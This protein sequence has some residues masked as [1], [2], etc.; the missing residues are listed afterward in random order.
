MKTKH[1]F[2]FLLATVFSLVC[3]TPKAYA[4]FSDEQIAAL[5]AKVKSKV[6]VG[7]LYYHLD[8]NAK[9]NEKL[10][11]VVPASSSDNYDNYKGL[12]NA[13]IPPY[14]T[15]HNETYKVVA[16]QKIAFS[17][18]KDLKSVSIPST[19]TEI[20]GSAFNNSGLTSINLDGNGTWTSVGLDAFS[21]TPYFNTASNWENGVVLYINNC[22]IKATNAIESLKVKE[23]T[24]ILADGC[25]YL[26]YKE[27]VKLTEVSLPNSVEYIGDASFKKCVSL[28]TIHMSNAV[29]KIGTGAFSF[30]KSLESIEL[31]A[32][33]TYIE[34]ES[35]AYSTALKD[36]YCKGKV[37]F[38]SKTF[39]SVDVSNISVHFPW[40]YL[41][42]YKKEW[43][44]FNLV[45]E[46]FI[47][48]GIYYTVNDATQTAT[49]A[50]EKKGT[51]NYASLP[52][53][54][55]IP[56]TIK[57]AQGQEYKVVG[58]E[59]AAFSF[60]PIKELV[61]EAEI[62][63][64]PDGALTWAD[65][66]TKVTL[67]ASVRQISENAFNNCAVLENIPGLTDG[68][69]ELL[70]NLTI[71]GDYAFSDCAKLQNIW[72]ESVTDIGEDAFSLCTELKSVTL[73][74]KVKNIGKSAFHGCTALEKM[75]NKASQ[76]QTFAKSMLS[77]VDKEKFEIYVPGSSLNDYQT[78]EGW[79]DYTILGIYNQINGLYYKLNDYNRTATIV[80]EK[81]N[82]NDNYANLPKKLTI[83]EYISTNGIEYY[84]VTEIEKL[85][86]MYAPVKEVVL[87]ENIREIGS[88]AFEASQLEEINIPSADVSINM[89]AFRATKLQTLELPEGFTSVP[90]SLCLNCSS[91]YKVVL[92]SS[93][94]KISTSAFYGC[95][96]LGTIT[97][98]ENVTEIEKQA[99][100]N[101][102]DLYAIYNLNKTP[103]TI[104]AN[105]FE[106][107]T[108]SN[109]TLYVPTGCKAAY[110]AKD[111]WKEFTIKELNVVVDGLNYIINNDAK[112]AKLTF[113]NLV[114]NYTGLSGKVTIPATI[115]FNDETY[116]VT[117]I[118]N[119]AF[120]GNKNITELV[121]PE[122]IQKIG[123]D[124]IYNAAKIA[125]M[126]IPS[127]VNYIYRIGD[128]NPL[129]SNDANYTDGLL[130]I[131]NCLLKAK[132]DLSGKITV[133]DGTRLIAGYA[134]LGC[135][136][137]T[138]I[139]LPETVQ[140]I[141]D[142]TFQDCKKLQGI[143]IPEGIT[144]LRRGTFEYCDDL[145]TYGHAIILP[146]SLVT[147][148][149][150]VFSGCYNLREIT[151]P[152]NVRSIGNLMFWDYSNPSQLQEL[153][154]PAGIQELKELAFYDLGKLV[155]F[156]CFSTTPEDIQLGD[157]VFSD[158]NASATLFVPYGYKSKYEALD[159]WKDLKI[160]EM[161]VQVNG[162]Y[163]ET[164]DVHHTAAVTREPG[165]SAPMYS[166]FETTSLTIP[167][168]IQVFNEGTQTYE[169]YTVDFMDDSAFDGAPF[170]TVRL[171]EGMK[172]LGAEVFSGS[173]LETVYLPS[174]IN[175]LGSA[176]MDCEHLKTV[177]CY[178]PDPIDIS[179][180]PFE[181]VDLP[182]A[183]LYVP[184]GCADAYNAA[185][186]WKDF[187]TIKEMAVCVNGLFYELDKV[188]HEATVTYQY[189][190]SE[191]NYSGF[192][193]YSDLVDKGVIIPATITVGGQEYAVKAI[194]N[195]AFANSQSIS[196]LM[197]TNGITSI[198]ARAFANTYIGYVLMPPTITS[199]GENAFDERNFVYAYSEKPLAINDNVFKGDEY[200]G[201]VVPYGCISAYEAA[202]GW[203]K[204][205]DIYDMNPCIDN[206]YYDWNEDSGEAAVISDWHIYI[207]NG[208]N[209]EN[210]GEKVVIPANIVLNEKKYKVTD[211]H[212]G[213]F[214]NNKVLKHITLPETLEYINYGAFRN[215]TALETI[216]CLGLKPAIISDYYCFEGV[217]KEKIT[218]YVYR[219]ALDDYKN[220]NIWK[221]FNILPLETPI[222]VAG[223]T[224]T[225]EQYGKPLTGDGITGE[226][227][228]TEGKVILGDG[229]SIIT[230]KMDVPA[231]ELFGDDDMHFTI[232]GK[233]ATLSGGKNPAVRI[234]GDV[235]INFNS[236]KD[237]S[238]EIRSEC[239]DGAIALSDGTKADINL[240][241][242][243]SNNNRIKIFSAYGGINIPQTAYCYIQAGGYVDIFVNGYWCPIGF[244]DRTLSLKNT[245]MV[246][247]FGGEIKE[248]G[249]YDAF[250]VAVSHLSL[251]PETNQS[252]KVYPVELKGISVTEGNAA[253]I[254]G[255]GKSSYDAETNT[256]TLNGANISSEGVEV[257]SATEGL[258]LQVVGSNTLSSKYESAG[259]KVVEGDFVIFGEKDA[260]LTVNSINGVQCDLSGQYRMEVKRCKVD[261][262]TTRYNSYALLTDSLYVN[263]GSLFM[264][265]KGEFYPAWISSNPSKSGGLVLRH[266]KVTSGIVNV[267]KK[268]S[269]EVENPL[270]FK[271][272]VTPDDEAHGSVKGGGMYEDGEKITLTATAGEGYKFARWDDGVLDNPRELTVDDDYTLKAV[273]AAKDKHI[274]TF[275]GFGGGAVK[276]EEVSDGSAATAPELD[277]VEGWHF[278]KWDT[279]FSNVTSS[280][281][282]TAIYEK[283]VYTV[284]FLGYEE[285][286]LKTEKVEHGGSATAPEAPAVEH[287]TFIGWEPADFGDITA[288]MT[289]KA[290]YE[291]DMFTVTFRGLG[292]KTLSTQSVPYGGAAQAPAN[293]EEEGYTF[294]GWDKTFDVITEDLVVTALYESNTKTY[295]LT[296]EKEGEG[297]IFFG[298]YNA[299]GDLQESEATEKTYDLPEGS[300]FLAIAK[301]AEGWQFSRW[302]DGETKDQR[303]VTMNA[304]I[305]L[306]AVFTGIPVAKTFTVTFVDWDDTVIKTETVSEG[307]AA[308]APDDPV[309]EGYTFIGWDGFFNEV[310]ADITLKAEYEIN[311]YN[312]TFKNWDGTV[313]FSQAVAWG[314]G[315]D[316]P[317]SPYREGY[318]FT[319][320][321][322][323]YSVVKEDMVITAQFEIVK[324]TVVF[325]GKGGDEL[326]RQSVDW[327]GAAV[328]PE[329]PAVE[330]YTFKG[331]DTDFSQVTT[332][333]IVNAE[334]EVNTYT[335]R[336]YDHE[337]NLLTT[338]TVN[339]NEK[340]VEPLLPD[341]AGHSFTAW[342]VEFDHVKSDL[343]IKPIYDVN[344]YKVT[345]IG[346]DG[347]TA[348]KTENVVYGEKA[349][350]P[351]AP[352]VEGYTFKGWDADFNEVT[353]DITIKAQYEI[354]T[355]TVRFYDREDNVISTQTVEWNEAAKEPELEA[356]EGHL[357]KGWSAAFD[358]VKS[359][360]DIKPVYEVRTYTVTF[361][362]FDG[363]KL[364]EQAVY[365][366]EAAGGITAPEVEGYTFTGWDKDFEHVTS[367][368][369]VTAQ[370]Q[371]D[372]A[373][374]IEDTQRDSN[375][376]I[377]VI[378]NGVLYILRDGK[379]YNAQ[380]A[381]VK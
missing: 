80:A 33:L 126:N 139:V 117:E 249:I 177:Y 146:N 114:N 1:L 95:S 377:K 327:K 141:G 365:W 23:G 366:N 24:N 346:F 113:D 71:I 41:S 374:G 325:Y 208:S 295:K 182:Q 193:N 148:E 138:E 103:Q 283:N 343:D 205:S 271:V 211:I 254:L 356:W 281:T 69:T 7:D 107:L 246:Y 237:E 344:T 258:N 214:E 358:H 197:I 155:N 250:G 380:G 136:E 202:D 351:E 340:A 342:S 133:K 272:D 46:P 27:N 293:V 369:I 119:Y 357:F 52:E 163:Y 66:L 364:G 47:L 206:I 378:R 348:L 321:D 220:A 98:P 72:L 236:G 99:F 29:K 63:E 341:W 174:T 26:E 264:E 118:G 87:P 67:P 219:Q 330:G 189:L 121:L 104:D 162:I 201:L 13:D 34:S 251:A 204:A 184:Y 94:I 59:D 50:P 185:D 176:F 156:Y 128:G 62:T 284:T 15:Y 241:I 124:V 54:V 203:K 355:Y 68:N 190:N 228:V 322:K 274:V 144:I 86:F 170:K 42:F 216:T 259:I 270:V 349:T 362:G 299:L 167:A 232:S 359:N 31:P 302:A 304:D 238:L 125:K 354:N 55:T 79:K 210:L 8:N 294:L 18:A 39:E 230:D 130:Y 256:L 172:S 332:D 147:V 350:A 319:G 151:F 279:D 192:T 180:G 338:Q 142:Y 70:P 112:T 157:K 267:D 183:T 21:N 143:N 116:Q 2:L 273:F 58:L 10:A 305:T 268:M 303:A 309:R 262:T 168:Q 298:I 337:G 282:V 353:A 49:V 223:Q 40:Q 235:T 36:I 56:K 101:C 222:M 154:L 158:M 301:P 215:C 37:S 363:K 57:D 313:V 106:G 120:E 318:T 161:P 108:L 339:W 226:V 225:P 111:V 178:R 164:E 53:V 275:I 25:L 159:Q 196:T 245:Y 110:E 22:L 372:P 234:N 209:Y 320:W 90:R 306:K 44:G 105:V 257:L 334:Y 65:K 6:K 213:S 122:G 336:F 93:L 51:G 312:V 328:A 91:L 352:E 181:F 240:N 381:T 252:G 199:I 152:E 17:K 81:K 289:V 248:D 239:A 286:E 288:D 261:I 5:I 280:L 233:N 186:G 32:S 61:I 242:G 83:P 84:K 329:A 88:G 269:I 96:E 229:A 345:F 187:G 131:D 160:D 123:C 335:V 367:D 102:T 300:Q 64:I 73:G 4:Q 12:V 194:G 360:L 297:K 3:F 253:D 333:L 200:Y 30:C 75:T 292:E 16:I 323:D 85:A 263:V 290:V 78:A 244:N 266:S 218:V 231:I 35:F 166:F 97:I 38:N 316:T 311:Y 19:V 315:A 115:T 195:D 310:N 307:G 285:A 179:A 324:Y 296:L 217:D 48:D 165:K 153:V 224:V 173:D 145:G 89:A 265:T 100:G 137:I 191:Y 28:K 212:S 43:K 132:K 198:G 376:G 314:T 77:G 60:A 134:F 171:P 247:P 175:D 74:N 227:I 255:D 308:N 135:K 368:M 221:E 347:E 370:Y 287:Y 278:V 373:T 14:I 20:G 361:I 277:E 371:K 82:N 375:R 331:W 149:R 109:I 11:T 291:I 243:E 150:E 127:T 169:V 207:N 260:T 129:I 188:K 140:E 92:P 9:T 276:Y 76:P 379:T 45:P 326:S 317:K